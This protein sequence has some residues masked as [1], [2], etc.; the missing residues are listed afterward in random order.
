M[1]KDNYLIRTATD[2]PMLNISRLD[3]KLSV[4]D[5][6][7]HRCKADTKHYSLITTADLSLRF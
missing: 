2:W 4:I 6:Y 3:F 5:T 7:D 1:S